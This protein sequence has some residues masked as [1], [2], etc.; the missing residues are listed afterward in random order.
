MKDALVYS[1]IELKYGDISVERLIPNFDVVNLS[2]LGLSLF[3]LR[4]AFLS[5]RT[6]S[7]FLNSL[8]LHYQHQTCLGVN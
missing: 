5:F 3:C 2:F 8:L 7:S 4:K 6:E 1:C